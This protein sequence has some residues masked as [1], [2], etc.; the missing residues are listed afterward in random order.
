MHVPEEKNV[1]FLTIL[2]RINKI[3]TSSGCFLYPKSAKKTYLEGILGL[4]DE[5]NQQFVHQD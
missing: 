4:L 1:K 5:A 2:Y 3:N